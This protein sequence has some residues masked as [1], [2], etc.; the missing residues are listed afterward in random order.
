MR[1]GYPEDAQQEKEM[2]DDPAIRHRH[3][4]G[5]V[6][7]GGD[8]ADLGNAVVKGP[9]SMDNQISDLKNQVD[10][11][12][13]AV[14]VSEDILTKIRGSQPVNTA[15]NEKV[16]H[17]PNSLLEDLNQ[18]GNRLDEALNKLS[19]NLNEITELI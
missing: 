11:A 6:G 10:K 8:I 4:M 17:Q 16:P 14:D 12:R 9:T 18:I 5:N 1:T 2:R 7:M 13:F 3:P 15:E 19:K